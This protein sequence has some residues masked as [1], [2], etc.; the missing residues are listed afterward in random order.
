MAFGCRPSCWL[1]GPGPCFLCPYWAAAPLR[2]CYAPWLPWEYVNVGILHKD[3]WTRGQMRSAFAQHLG[4]DGVEGRG[5]PV[6]G[7]EL[8]ILEGWEGC[9]RLLSHCQGHQSCC[10]LFFEDLWV[11][12]TWH[13]NPSQGQGG[14]WPQRLA[15][16]GPGGYSGTGCRGGGRRPA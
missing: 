14:C 3:T 2:L 6:L 10:F 12:M 7:G 5:W 4:G 8:Q 15:S 13:K 16:G 1:Y 9:A 11:L